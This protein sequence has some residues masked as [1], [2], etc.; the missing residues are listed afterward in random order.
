MISLCLLSVYSQSTPETCF[1]TDSR[2]CFYNLT[3][4]VVP[5]D[6][7]SGD[8][9]TFPID[10]EYAQGNHYINI[11]ESINPSTT[12]CL[13]GE[14]SCQQNIYGGTIS[15]GRTESGQFN[16][17]DGDDGSGKTKQS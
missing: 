14:S 4:L 11:C 1:Y 13:G 5:V 6:A 12:E 17:Y 7:P 10:N 16:E 8:Y 2:G 15:C 3:S 9:Y